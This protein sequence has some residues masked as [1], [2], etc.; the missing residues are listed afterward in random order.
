[1]NKKLYFGLAAL[2]LVMLACAPLS[3]VSSPNNVTGSGN[4]ISE[5]RA[6][7][8]FN[9]IDLQGSGSVTVSLGSEESVV[10]EADDNIV[11]LITTDVRNGTLVIATKDNTNITTRNGIH[12][13]VAMKSLKNVTLSG[14]GEIQAKGK[15]GDS[16]SVNLPGSGSI[17]VEGGVASLDISLP[18][19]GNVY[20][21]KLLARSATVT[22]NG[23]GTIAVYASE[24]LDATLRGSGTIR[25]SGNPSQVNKSITG[26]GTITP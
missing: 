8:G 24:S 12:I 23:S 26:S 18:G 15:M 4:I 21:D 10:I 9:S 17:T 14:S 6:V 1:M 16:L 13:T 2:M 3:L 25:Y 20:C 5:S 7:S 19:S 11:P 22:L